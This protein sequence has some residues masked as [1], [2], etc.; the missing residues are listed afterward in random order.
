MKKICFIILTLLLGLNTFS[1]AFEGE[2]IYSNSYKSKNPQMKDE[3][4]AAYM[5][6]TQT[7]TIKNGDYKST[8]NG[9]LIQW[10][11]YVNKDNKLYNKI[12]QSEA[13]FWN[14]ASVQDDEVLKTEL[15][16]G[17]ADILGYKCDELVLYCKSGVQKY[18]F[19]AKIG[20]DAKLFTKHKFGNWYDFVSR[21]N[22]LPLKSILETEQFTL[23]SVATKV[24]P[25]KIDPK[26]LE[27]PS[28]IK[29]EKSP[30]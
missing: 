11:V 28:G 22:A 20:V 30:Y 2:I 4:W 16:K 26:Q 23:T 18:Y 13:A 29:T 17:V 10:Q 12:S 24:T 7:Y 14:D 3:Q 1:Q 19:N 15:N 5:G 25:M 9:S 27:L 8:M 21:A 6:D